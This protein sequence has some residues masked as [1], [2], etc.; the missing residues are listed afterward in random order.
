MKKL[1]FTLGDREVWEHDNKK[2]ENGNLI[3]YV[4]IVDCKIA[5]S[6]YLKT[7]VKGHAKFRPLK[8]Y[9]PEDILGEEF[10]TIAWKGINSNFV[11][12]DQALLFGS[13]T[14]V[15]DYVFECDTYGKS[16]FTPKGTKL[17]KYECDKCW[18]PR[19]LWIERAA[20][21]Q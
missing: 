7:N 2:Y 10:K 12:L 5:A 20:S 9:V 15:K 16:L 4:K 11:S 18:S 14:L 19:L 13:T 3:E 21:T 1:L 17:L 6:I 8:P